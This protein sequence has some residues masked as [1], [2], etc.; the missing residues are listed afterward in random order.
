MLSSDDPWV[1][2]KATTYL[3]SNSVSPYFI[4]EFSPTPKDV[5]EFVDNSPKIKYALEMIKTLHENESTKSRGSFLYIGKE[6][7]GFTKYYEEW[8]VKKRLINQAK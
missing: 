4:K 2:L 1:I 8:L 7:V 6:W 5:N 3:K